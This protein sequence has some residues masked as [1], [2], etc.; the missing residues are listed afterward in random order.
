MNKVL[1]FGTSGGYEKVK[2][3]I[4]EK[5]DIV[6]FVDNHS[7]DLCLNGKNIILPS[8]INKYSYDYIFIASHSYY[9][10]IKEQLLDMKIEEDKVLC[11]IDIYEELYYNEWVSSDAKVLPFL[12]KIK[13]MHILEYINKYKPSVLVETG[14]FRG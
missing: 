5:Y 14:T 6:A 3:I 8:D 4:N 9:Y 7:N 11:F 2:D 12:N 10:E 1:V 13:Q